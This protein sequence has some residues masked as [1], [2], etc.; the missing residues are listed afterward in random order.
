M[1]AQKHPKPGPPRCP[2]P[3][4]RLPLPAARCLRI[5][6]AAK[7]KDNNGEPRSINLST[8]RASFFDLTRAVA[9]C[10]K[11]LR[12]IGKSRHMAA[13]SCSNWKN[14]AA[15]TTSAHH[16]CKWRARSADADADADSPN[17]CRGQ[18][19]KRLFN[20]CFCFLFLFLFFSGVGA[21]NFSFVSH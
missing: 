7:T 12:L 17:K 3:V 1:D 5:S 14:C 10:E 8:M 6:T 13:P 20:F 19:R 4:A 21:I 11:R 2:L 18:S 9:E 15:S 16:L